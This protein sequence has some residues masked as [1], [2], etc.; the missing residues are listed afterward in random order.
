MITLLP[1]EMLDLYTEAV[2]RLQNV[3]LSLDHKNCHQFFKPEDKI[4]CL[5]PIHHADKKSSK[6]KGMIR[7]MPILN[8]HAIETA[9]LSILTRKQAAKN[10]VRAGE[11][12]ENKSDERLIKLVKELSAG[13]SKEVY[14]QDGKAV[15]ERTRVVLDLPAL[16]LK[17]KQYGASPINVSLTEF[18][19]FKVA[20]LKVPVD[21]LKDVPEDKLESQYLIFLQRLQ[22]LTADYE[23]VKLKK[24]DPK[25]LIKK[26]FDPTEELFKSIEL[27]MQAIA[28]CAIK[29]SCES[30]LESFVSRYENH[31]DSRRNTE[32]SATNEEF[33]IAVNGPNLANCD[34]VVM[35]A[36]TSYWSS[37]GGDM[38][39]FRK[40]VIEK[41]KSFQF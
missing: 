5:W 22:N 34:G 21:D 4:K 30:V 9:G 23:E 32:E 20:V 26:F 27:I 13:L 25:E 3:A 15:I 6:E 17:L 36:M 8:K 31:F 28:V 41:L 29:H 10:I 12:P 19:K 11:D 24:V 1:H 39:F 33:E 2:T 37:R 35:E 40:S 16:A 38:H 14:S 18:P 7:D